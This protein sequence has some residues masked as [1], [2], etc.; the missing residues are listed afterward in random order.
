MILKL[1]DKNNSPD[2]LQRIADVLNDG[3]IIIYP[4]DQ[5]ASKNAKH[6]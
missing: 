2:D 1:Y 3:G 6:T 4:T 5:S